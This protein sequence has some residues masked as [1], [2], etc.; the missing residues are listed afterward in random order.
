MQQD[1]KLK[2]KRD[3]LEARERDLTLAEDDFSEDEEQDENYLA[4]VK[5]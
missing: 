5:L 3:A 1:R 2:R 4:E